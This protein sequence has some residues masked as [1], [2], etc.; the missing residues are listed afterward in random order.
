MTM[1]T[2]TNDD[3]T[4]C[5]FCDSEVEDGEPCPGCEAYREQSARE[6]LPKSFCDTMWPPKVD[7]TPKIDDLYRNRNTG[8]LHTV[9]D[10]KLSGGELFVCINRILTTL[11]GLEEWYE[12]VKLNVPPGYVTTSQWTR[13][14]SGVD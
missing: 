1:T 10:V 7:A 2:T 13:I 11:E 6:T 5:E 3:R 12:S 8:A 14:E 9:D 4:I